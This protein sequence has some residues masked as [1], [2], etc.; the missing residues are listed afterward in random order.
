MLSLSTFRFSS[1]NYYL[2]CSLSIHK[3]RAL[4]GIFNAIY[5]LLTME[6]SNNFKIHVP[7]GSLKVTPVNSSRVISHYWLILPEA[8]YCTVYEIQPSIGPPSLYSIT[9]CV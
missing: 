9:P 4:C 7:D 2:V 8:E 1:I 5:V 3:I 6:N